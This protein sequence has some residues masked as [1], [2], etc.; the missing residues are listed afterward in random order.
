MS[1]NDAAS[2]DMADT[3]AL[4]RLSSTV[5][6][7][8]DLTERAE[9]EVQ[10]HY[11]GDI[12]AGRLGMHAAHSST[13]AKARK[14]AHVSGYRRNNRQHGAPVMSVTFVNESLA[15]GSVGAGYWQT[16]RATRYRALLETPRTA[17]LR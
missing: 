4:P 12:P 5:V 6:R 3:G 11:C 10:P 16:R 14:P 1:T 17:R 13:L 2:M 9:A 8:K 7:V 15:E